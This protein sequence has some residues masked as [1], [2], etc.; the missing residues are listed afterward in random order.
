MILNESNE[1]RLFLK[2]S[3]NIVTHAFKHYNDFYF[4]G[5]NLTYFEGGSFK[6]IF[7]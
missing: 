4:W 5:V 2:N 1:D 7:T 6:L 3:L